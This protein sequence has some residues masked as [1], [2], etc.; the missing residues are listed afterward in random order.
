MEDRTRKGRIVAPAAKPGAALC[1]NASTGCMRRLTYS[2]QMVQWGRWK[3]AGLTEAEAGEI[4]PLCQKC[5][6]AYL[7]SRS[8]TA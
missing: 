4:L 1:K 5:M 7:R 2:E 8:T 3:R 6:T